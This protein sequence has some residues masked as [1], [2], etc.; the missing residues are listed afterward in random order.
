[1]PIKL[2][3]YKL[4]TFLYKEQLMLAF[5]TI[6]SLMKCLNKPYFKQYNVINNE[7]VT[8]IK[9]RVIDLV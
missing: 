2:H 3:P 9:K 8:N 6:T 1:M 5:Q 4:S 7:Q